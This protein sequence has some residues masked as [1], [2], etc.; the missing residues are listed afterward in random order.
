MLETFIGGTL[1]HS[2]RRPVDMGEEF[3]K[4]G[5]TLITDPKSDYYLRKYNENLQL[6]TPFKKRS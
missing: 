3:I 4:S 1:K 5:M 6:A 2:I